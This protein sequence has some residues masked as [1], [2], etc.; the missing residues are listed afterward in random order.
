MAI[1]RP[2]RQARYDW[3]KSKG[4]IPFEA[5][6]ISKI[7]D[8]NT[9]H[10]R[11]MMKDRREIIDGLLREAEYNRWSKLRTHQEIIEYIRYIYR[12]NRWE[13]NASG[14]WQ[15]YRDYR[16][17]A[18]DLGEYYPK[19]RRKKRFGEEGDRIDRGKLKEQRKRY[20]ERLKKRGY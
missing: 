11:Q 16:D 2:R 4:F 6:E 18:I 19:R 8:R 20:K 17:K 14:L 3:A 7:T 15:M 5:R 13:F 9:P 1:Y 10:F 12:D